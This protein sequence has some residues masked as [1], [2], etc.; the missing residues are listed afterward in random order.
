M[1][2]DKTRKSKRQRNEAPEF[3]FTANKTIKES[4]SSDKAIH[5]SSS[6][7]TSKH[8]KTKPIEVEIEIVSKAKAGP[9][10]PTETEGE[11]EVFEQDNSAQNQSLFEDSYRSACSDSKEHLLSETESELGDLSDNSDKT[12]DSEEKAKS[13]SDPDSNDSISSKSDLSSH[14]S[15]S[16]MSH[17]PPPPPP[18]VTVGNATTMI[19]GPMMFS[20][21]ENA[22]N[23][24]LKFEIAAA[25]NNWDGPLKVQYIGMY[26]N[27]TAQ[28]WYY[29]V[30][31]KNGGIHYPSWV[32]FR[33]LFLDAF[34]EQISDDKIREEIRNRKKIEGE[35]YE[36][37]YY[38]VQYLCDLITPATPM[39][40]SKRVKHLL[41]GLTK[42]LARK[43]W[44]K[45]PKTP[46]DVLAALRQQE[47]FEALYG[48]KTSE[49]TTAAIEQIQSRTNDEFDRLERNLRSIQGCVD[50]LSAK[51]NNMATSQVNSYQNNGRNDGGQYNN[52][53]QYNNNWQSNGN[54]NGNNTRGNNQ[55][56]YD[57]SESKPNKYN[58]RMFTKD[59]RQQAKMDRTPDGKIICWH[60]NKIGH[61]RRECRTLKREN[62]NKMRGD[63]QTK[64]APEAQ[65]GN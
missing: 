51:I 11:D 58:S 9:S 20:G 62:G 40:D 15:S 47:Q 14:S 55:R 59:D 7:T 28:Q 6:S 10:K 8:S 64:P 17:T 42:E 22:R 50:K 36:S 48:R 41:K 4:L 23:W 33:K 26:F 32:D 19:P 25:A 52:K 49:A 27:D 13:K 29:N 43:V 18:P 65:A 46:A 53:G 60:C 30:V 63:N 24:L 21:K 44:E 39:D 16:K 45:T 31:N 54:R 2:D 56:S 38:A 1:D 12:D 3:D 37:Y 5:S 35:T 34:I 61:V 57:D